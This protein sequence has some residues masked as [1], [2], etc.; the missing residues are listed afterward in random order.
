MHAW[1]LSQHGTDDIV[2]RLTNC[3]FTDGDDVED[4]AGSAPTSAELEPAASRLGLSGSMFLCEVSTEW[5]ERYQHLLES[6]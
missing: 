1:S 5:Y 3:R 6:R 2:R 4:A